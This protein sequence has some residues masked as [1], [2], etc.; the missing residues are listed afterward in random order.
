MDSVSSH[1]RPFSL[2]DTKRL[3]FE[4]KP[5]TATIKSGTPAGFQFEGFEVV[6][7]FKTKTSR[8][9]KK[10][11]SDQFVVLFTTIAE[12][13]A[14]IDKAFSDFK[15]I[16]AAIDA[17][18]QYVFGFTYE[19]GIRN[20]TTSPAIVGWKDNSKAVLQN[21]ELGKPVV[22]LEFQSYPVLELNDWPLKRLLRAISY[23]RKAH[24]T[25][26]FLMSLHATALSTENVDV[27]LTLLGKLVD[28][29]EILLPGATRREKI[30][31]LPPLFRNRLV[32]DTDL[33]KIANTR[34]LT[35]HA[36]NKSNKQL[37]PGMT[38]GEIEDFQ[39]DADTLARFLV[40]RD[41][42]TQPCFYEGWRFPTNCAVRWSGR[43]GK[44]RSRQRDAKKRDRAIL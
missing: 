4:S 20:E 12:S 6:E 22:H 32:F 24:D 39:S 3:V 5:I 40:F 13:K 11:K 19:G 37:H 31:S 43:I 7:A 15:A 26:K 10:A 18:W 41:L 38:P 36:A 25:R 29:C 33:F 30:E 8:D 27:R 16:K 9:E 44:D 1:I 35:R 21:L 42:G 28:L 34:S 17:V 2:K 23:Y 14:D